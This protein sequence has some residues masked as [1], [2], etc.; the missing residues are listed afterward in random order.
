[1]LKFS[2][3][4]A[5]TILIPLLLA[6][7]VEW[8]PR[9][10]HRLLKWTAGRL[11]DEATS[12]RYLEEWQAELAETPGGLSQLIYALS[13]TIRLPL[14]AREF[15]VAV[16]LRPRNEGAQGGVKRF[17]RRIESVV[18]GF[19]FNFAVG[20][21]LIGAAALILVLEVFEPILVILLFAIVPIHAVLTGL[22][23]RR[24]RDRT[25][26]QG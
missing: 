4:V 6:L 21:G 14:M 1:M 24:I 16:K 10:A 8:S 19:W 13:R 12:A 15:K 18:L 25:R 17:S 2:A 5:T 11:G 22:A 9:I 3:Y 26:T 7:L 20:T 23:V